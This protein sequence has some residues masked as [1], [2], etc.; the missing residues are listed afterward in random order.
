MYTV[1]HFINGRPLLGGHG[2]SLVYNPALGEPVGRVAI[3]DE[4]MVDQAISAASRA[5]TAWSQASFGFRSAVMFRFRELMAA[6]TDDL[7]EMIT[8]EEGKTLADARGEVGRALDVVEYVCGIPE[9]L[10]GE[11]TMQAS[12]D[13]DVFSFR[14]PLGVAAGVTPFNFPAMCPMWMAPVAIACGNTFVL[15]PAKADPSASVRLAEL[16]T[17]AGLPDGVF[18]VV[19]GDRSTVGLLHAHPDI[20]SISFVGS[21]AVGRDLQRAGVAHGKR[22]QALTSAKNHGIVLADADLDFA[23]SSTVASAFGAAGER[24]MALPVVLV[25]DRVADAFVGRLVEQAARVR[26]DD[27]MA[28]NADMGPIIS[29]AERDR[30][31]LIV[32]QAEDAGATILLDGRGF[33]PPTRQRGFFTG[34]TI[35]DHV[36]PQMRAYSEEVFGP[37]LVVQRIQDLDEGIQIITAN[38]YGN[39]AAIFTA[40]GASARRFTRSV[41]V[42]MIGVNVPIPVPVAYHSF[43]GLRDSFFGETKIYGPEGVH[44]FT[45]SKTVSQRWIAPTQPTTAHF[46]FEGASSASS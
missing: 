37:V 44:F 1:P 15:K 17:Q 28:P 9:L 16:W 35:L 25:E 19:Q 4:S 36:T 13:L 33:R 29:E 34:P 5:F 30:I 45:Q 26:V 18:N 6:A 27:G 32:T 42:G 31:E 43:G 7:A 12:S 11:Y 40:S 22:V 39:G 8:R 3:A 38:P 46:H 21:T 2:E 41:P 24:C 20:R 14:E 23:V 10:K